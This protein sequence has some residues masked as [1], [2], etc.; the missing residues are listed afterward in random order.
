MI[1]RGRL[2]VLV[3][4]GPEEVALDLAATVTRI[5]LASE[6]TASEGPN[7]TLP[8][9]SFAIAVLED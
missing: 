8:A 5:L 9:E 7:I 4:L 1:H 3:N 2:R 6:P